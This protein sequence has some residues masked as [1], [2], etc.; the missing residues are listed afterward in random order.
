ME[1]SLQHQARIFAPQG[2][3]LANRATPES[4]H[5]EQAD[6]HEA[7]DTRLGY[8]T[9]GTLSAGRDDISANDQYRGNFERALA[10]IQARAILITCTTG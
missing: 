10:A 9:Y 8:K 5:S 4:R 7:D 6:G 3:T 1:R 2:N